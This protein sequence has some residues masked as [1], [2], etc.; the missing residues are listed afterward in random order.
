MPGRRIARRR[1][2]HRSL[3]RT[4]G[5]GGHER[6]D[7]EPCIA[8]AHVGLSL[9]AP[10]PQPVSRFARKLRPAE[11]GERLLDPAARGE[12]PEREID[13]IVTARGRPREVLGKEADPGEEEREARVR[14]S[15]F[16]PSH[17]PSSR[18]GSWPAWARQG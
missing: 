16:L 13:R 18:T 12:V 10:V 11:R 6:L 4:R 17:A 9:P 8:L 7:R 1:A 14:S 2:Q 3:G 15:A 5:R